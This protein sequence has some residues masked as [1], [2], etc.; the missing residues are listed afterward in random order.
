MCRAYS[1]ISSMSY[2]MRGMLCY[3]LSG[4]AKSVAIVAG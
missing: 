1:W 4:P 3:E 2:K